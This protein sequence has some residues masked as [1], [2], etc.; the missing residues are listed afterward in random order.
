MSRINV[1]EIKDFHAWQSVAQ[2]WNT[3]LAESRADV[4]FLTHEWLTSWAEC[5]LGSDRRLFILAFYENEK[6]IGIAPL[7]I[8]HIKKGLFRRRKIQFLGTPDTGSDYLDVFTRRGREQAVA[9]AFFDFLFGAGRS[10]WDHL[11]FTDIRADSL[12]LL[13]FSTCLELAGKYSL[14]SRSAY[15][16]VLYL[17]ASEADLYA[18]FSSGWRKKYKQDCRVAKRDYNLVFQEVHG[19]EVRDYLD[20]FFNTYQVKGGW[21]VGKLLPVLDKLLDKSV[22]NS[23]VQLNFLR[24]DNDVIA[25]LLHL[26]YKKQRLMFLMAVDKKYNSKISFGNILVGKA[27]TDAIAAK[28]TVYDFLK[29]IE[30]YKFHWANGG[31]TTVELQIWQKNPGSLCAAF[32][33]LLNSAGK[34]L[35]R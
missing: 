10:L 6:L 1:V 23:A 24:I 25:A 22:E 3:L 4:F 26:Q 34:L 27:I 18:E 17:P 32:L 14:L 35:L 31:H 2:D 29:G 13:Y 20:E 19:P 21:S 8:Q 5:C 7:Y 16:P 28:Y 12:F 30:R 11:A 15:C 33:G 9:E